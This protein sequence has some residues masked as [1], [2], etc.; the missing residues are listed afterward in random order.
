MATIT[1]KC[2]ITEI[3]R[4]I[5]GSNLTHGAKMVGCMFYM[6]DAFGENSPSYRDMSI[7][8]NIH[9]NTAIK[10]VKELVDS[11]FLIKKTD[12]QKRENRFFPVENAPNF[13]ELMAS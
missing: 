1:E 10:A 12:H 5:L 4:G 9:R 8:A 6:M 3:T 2:T 13:R 11:G 7:I